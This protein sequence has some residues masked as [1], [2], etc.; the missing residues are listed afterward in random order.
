MKMHLFVI[1]VLL[2]LGFPFIM[3]EVVESF[4]TCSDFFLNGQPPVIPGILGNSVSQDN[5]R[6]KLICQKYK[7]AYRFATVYDT[8]SKIPVFSAYKYTGKKSFKRPDVNWMI[9]P[10]AINEDYSGNCKVN[11]GHL[12]PNSHAADEDTAESTFTLTNAVPQ[13]ISFNS[14]SWSDMEEET[15]KIINN[16]KNENKILA[17]VLTGAIPG[18]S[19]L[20]KK[21]NIPS[22]MW[23]AFCCYNSTE[24]KWVS[25]AYW[26]PNVEENKK[27]K[28]VYESVQKLQDFFNQNE[29]ENVQLFTNNC[30]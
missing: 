14:G 11:R 18:N 9:E 5:N 12:F 21:V 13:M 28:I 8:T 26:A 2:V 25:Q 22:F 20:D 7:G 27:V 3:T 15:K 19:T 4:N 6:Y 16:C 10:E 24:K 23:M 17:H 30:N 1:S 29:M